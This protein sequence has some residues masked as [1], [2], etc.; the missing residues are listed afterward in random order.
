[1]PNQSLSNAE[2]IANLSPAERGI[3]LPI[4]QNELLNCDYLAT[5]FLPY[6]WKLEGERKLCNTKVESILE[7]AETV[8]SDMT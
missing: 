8:N 2:T 4:L 3:F 5:S 7:G 1:M 6:I